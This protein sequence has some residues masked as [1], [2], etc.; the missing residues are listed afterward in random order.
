MA[1]FW[2]KKWQYFGIAKY[3]SLKT[4][5]FD[6]AEKDSG[7]RRHLVR[8][9]ESTSSLSSGSGSKAQYDD[10][11]EERGASHRSWSTCSKLLMVV[12][13]VVFCSSLAL[14]FTGFY[15][16]SSMP[17][18]AYRKVS[19]WCKEVAL[20]CKLIGCAVKLIFEFSPSYG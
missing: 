7:V 10:D 9:S 8:G 18:S 14:F 11:D 19:T 6:D 13:L 2:A 16:Q 4:D 20:S 17:N 5:E 3:K 1:S 15:R 12:N